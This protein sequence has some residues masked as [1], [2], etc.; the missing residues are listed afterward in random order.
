MGS[1]YSIDTIISQ[2]EL[3][4]V[5]DEWNQ[6]SEFA[7]APN[8]FTTFGWYQAWSERL[9]RDARPGRLRPHVLILKRNRGVAGICP[10]VCRRRSRLGL[11]IRKLEF[12]GNHA[13]YNDLVLGDDVEGQTEAVVEYLSQTPKEWDLIDLRDVRD[14]G[15]SIAR[16]ESAL[17][18]VKLPY[19]L[20]PEQEQCPYMSIDGP[21]SEAAKRKHLRF[22]RRAFGGFAEKANMGFKVRIVESPQQEPGL[23]ERLIALEAQKHVGGKLSPPFLGRFPEVFQSLFDSLG[24]LDWITVVL[25]ERGDQLVAS[26]FLY[27][28]GGKLWDYVTAY[29]HSYSSLSPGTVLICAAIDYGFTHGF[30]EFD[31]LR[32]EES[33]KLRWTSEFR[34]NYRLLI[35]N[36]RWMSRLLSSAYLKLRVRQNRGT[37]S[38]LI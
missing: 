32:G 34:R 19:C 29:N 28:C 25:V 31:F 6:L 11:P 36:R 27:R 4:L 26:R 30:D 37:S 35:W 1:S 24:P 17:L 7:A 16:I 5:E 23:L 20:L 18:R 22:A 21:W 3:S 12:V 8:V 13:D 10:L 15:Y 2:G 38:L 14:T 33:Y 9:I